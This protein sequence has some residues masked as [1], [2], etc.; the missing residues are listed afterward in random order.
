MIF[1]CKNTCRQN[2]LTTKHTVTDEKFMKS[3]HPDF[4]IAHLRV[5]IEVVL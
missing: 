4:K 3:Y 2:V 5:F 1:F